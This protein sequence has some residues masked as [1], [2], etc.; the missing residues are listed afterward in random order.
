MPETTALQSAQN[1]DRPSEIVSRRR[2]LQIVGTA[3]IGSA[4]LQRALAQE[5]AKTGAITAEQ[6]ANAEWVAGI[7][8]S[9]S[10]RDALNS[11]L[12]KIQSDAEQ[13]RKISIEWDTI[14]ALRFDPEIAAPG[15]KVRCEKMPDWLSKLNEVPAANQPANAEPGNF[16]FLSIRELAR[17]LRAKEVTSVQLTEFCLDRL[18][19][20]DPVLNCVV[21]LTEDL[22]MEQ[23]RRA[24]DELA[25][26]HDR[27]PLHGIPWG[28]KDMIAVSGYATTWGAPQ[29]RDQHLRK[30]ATVAR[31]LENAG[32]VLVAKLSLGALAMG[33]EWFLGQ[34]KN[35]WNPA[36]GSS[37][38]SAGSASAVAAGLVPFAIGSE[39]LGS[40][41][42]PSKRC[43]VTGLRP[44][45]GR[46]SRA[47]CMTLS[48]TMDKLGPLA[49]T[50]DD[51]GTV[52]AAIQGVDAAD[53]TTVDRWY[54]WPVAADLSKLRIGHVTNAPTSESEQAAFDAL[55]V[56]GASI[57][58]VEL[59]R[60]FP[61]WALTAMLDVE[62]AESFHRLADNNNLEGI[63]AW[64]DIFRQ[65]HFV[66]AIDFLHA[67]R[68]RYNLMVEMAKVF[69]KV[70][71]YVGGGDLGI[72]NLTGHPMIALPVL[73]KQME[74]QSRPICCT[75]T[76]NLY[77][78]ATLLA[79]AQRIERHVDVV[80]FRP[81]PFSW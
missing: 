46:V 15:S 38:S 17:R 24:D 3:G 80:K 61:E 64:G 27:G 16:A 33:D 10:E 58:P 45:F 4:T 76:G 18:T 49:R 54:A 70:D 32:A 37:G 73:M 79:V 48:W 30:T 51:C 78:E 41:I 74:P 34:T 63:N 1:H 66:S 44:T 31:S 28:A 11:H 2:L 8:L 67:Q 36:Q 39:T 7:K 12:R 42:S 13:I 59:P 21:T 29:F 35:P 43:G 20:Y 22:A 57:V 75:L 52:L 65:A 69:E 19:T 53:P 40:M 68:A 77:D 62:A 6:I 56:L 47:G 23:A 9:E 81:K 72:T 26:G 50:V 55:K 25:A 5:A 14:P 60:Q 71:L